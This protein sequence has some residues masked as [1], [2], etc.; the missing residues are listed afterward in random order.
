M[1]RVRNDGIVELDYKPHEHQ[2][3]IHSDTRRFKVAVCHRRFGKTTMAINELIKHALINPGVY[4]YIAPTYKAAKMIAW[5]MLKHYTPEQVVDKYNE[6]ELSIQLKIPA[7]IG[8][9]RIYLKGSENPDM[10]RGAG[11]SGVVFD[12]YAEQSPDVWSKVV[13]PAL[14]ENKGWAWFI[15]TP[16]GSD[17]FKALFDRDEKDWSGYIL[18]ASETNVLDADELVQARQEMSEDE[19]NQEYECDFLTHT[20]LI[21]PEFKRHVHLFDPKNQ[22]F[23]EYWKEIIGIDHGYRNPTAAIFARVS[24]E[25]VIYVVDE[26]YERQKLV[27]EHAEAIWAKVQTKEPAFIIDPSTKQVHGVSKQS[28]HEEYQ[29]FG[30]TALKGNNQVMA[31]INRMKEHFKTDENGKCRLYIAKHCVNL[32]KELETYHWD[33]R[34]SV[35]STERD[36]PAKVGDHACDSLRYLIMSRPMDSEKPKDKQPRFSF[37]KQ[38]ERVSQIKKH[39]K[40]LGDYE[41]AW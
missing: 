10:L 25:G 35:Y 11:L 19:Y 5:D 40:V 33:T 20:G 12:E 4:W 36:K 17:H 3:V 29:D 7:K 28:V 14:S 30:I 15:G 34:T 18:K 13:R 8:Q 2:K 27:S 1:A 22:Q 26:H 31:G 41:V 21:Y 9:S 32:I 24:D 16:K 39:G 6:T 38:M 23:P 37:D